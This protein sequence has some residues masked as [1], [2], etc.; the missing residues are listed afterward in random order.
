MLDTSTCSD[1]GMGGGRGSRVMEVGNG[2][3]GERVAAL[4]LL[5]PRH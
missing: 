5:C 3:L 2:E 4:A 1:H